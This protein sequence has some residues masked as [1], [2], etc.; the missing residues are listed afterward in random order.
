MLRAAMKNS[1]K[2]E[3]HMQLA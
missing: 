2:E 1:G 3:E